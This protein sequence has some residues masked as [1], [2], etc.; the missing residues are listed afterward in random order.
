MNTAEELALRITG[1]SQGAQAALKDLEGTTKSLLEGLKSTIVDGCGPMGEAF[2]ATTALGVALGAALVELAAHAR[3][4]GADLERVSL[5]T[6][7]AVPALSDLKF[8]V[9]SA[10]GS[11]D[12]INNSMFM[13]QQRMEN[14][15][16]KVEQGLEQIGLSLGALKSL[17]PD[18]QFLAI[19]DALRS[20]GEETN[21]AAVAFDI[22]GRQGRDLLPLLLKP[23]GELV[24]KN[25]EL[26]LGWSGEDAE[27]AEKFEIKLNT[28]K[29]TAE[30]TWVQ[31]GLH[32]SIADEFSYAY[33]RM[34]L[35]VANVALTFTEDLQFAADSLELSLEALGI[36]GGT[37]TNRIL[38]ELPNVAGQATTSL[39]KLNE[40][41]QARGL[42]APT[43]NQA[44]ATEKE[45][46]HDDDEAH[47][48][49]AEATKKHNEEVAKF[50]KSVDDATYSMHLG[51]LELTRHEILVPHLTG[52]TDA[53]R[54]SLTYLD[55]TW[56]EFHDG[57]T[58]AGDTMSTVTIPMF[59]ELVST[60]RALA[61]E[62]NTETTP[63]TGSF[64]ASL[65]GLGKTFK[66]LATIEGSAFG[67][68]LK[69][70]GSLIAEYDLLK[71]ASANVK[72]GS[73]GTTK[74]NVDLAGSYATLGFAAYDAY[75]QIGT[76]AANSA[77]GIA[78]LTMEGATIGSMVP[79]LG[80]AVGAMIGFGVGVYKVLKGVSQDV[81]DSRKDVGDFEQSLW[82]LLTPTEAVEAAGRGWAASTIVVRDAYIATG[83]SAT[84]AQAAVDMLAQSAGQGMAAAKAAIQQVNAVLNEQKQDQADLDAAVKEYGF[85]LEQLG[86]MLQKQQLGQQASTIENQFRLLVGAGIDVAT[87]EDKMSG[88]INKYLQAV[89]ATGQQ[90]PVEMRPMLE[91]MAKMGELTDANGN[92]IT[93]LGAS[94]ITFAETMSSAADRI[95]AGFQKVMDKIFGITT[96]IDA[97]PKNTDVTITEHH[98]VTTDTTDTTTADGASLGGFVTATGIRHY[99]KGTANVL[100][101][102]RFLAKGTDT[103]PAMLTPGEAVLNTRAAATVGSDMI[104]RLNQGEGL[105][106]LGGGLVVN[107]DA[108]GSMF[109]DRQAMD[110]LAEIIS[111]RIAAKYQRFVKANVA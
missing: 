107:V 40:E 109:Q 102:P 98:T 9:E 60:A 93:D 87:V 3:E 96:A 92:K 91:Q 78:A 2:L 95:V 75:K 38:A 48:A 73:D 61:G 19:S 6:G 100:P 26:A 35:A 66:E 4:V 41:V 11:F 58:I 27:A 45:F 68:L 88:N 64:T 15:S 79:V 44:L 80:T 104:R 29:T 32:V 30:A 77:K 37:L 8:A 69:D 57:L 85:S 52:L 63:A 46:L 74:G 99:G 16:G 89:I 111:D 72:A 22:F 18:Q 43:L 56:N 55:G 50:K 84:E 49:T 20:T 13:F 10:G 97:I 67:G 105:S 1:D 31:L 82:A 90:V 94:G 103:V 42:L 59:S 28:V 47:K 110:D 14:S 21:K 23:L 33:Q 83:H 101:F 34:K 86:P 76:G 70:V 17:T 62:L 54:E 53:Y 36:V 12:Q 71:K 25:K 108:R 39:K 51:V 65:D 5:T 7:I 24:D 81:K 106:G